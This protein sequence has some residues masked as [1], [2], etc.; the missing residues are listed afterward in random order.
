MMKSFRERKVLWGNFGPPKN[1]KCKNAASCRLCNNYYG[2]ELDVFD[3]EV[4]GAACMPTVALVEVD[5]SNVGRKRKLAEA[6]FAVMY[7]RGMLRNSVAM[8]SQWEESEEE[9]EEGSGGEEEE[10]EIMYTR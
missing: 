2:S 10:Q 7:N 6:Q 9:S 8:L 1:S 5:R 3:C 4:E